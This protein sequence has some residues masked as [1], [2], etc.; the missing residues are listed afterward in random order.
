M[1]AG[2]VREGDERQ[3]KRTGMR[4]RVFLEEEK[5]KGK[6]ATRL[7]E[8]MAKPVTRHA[9]VKCHS[10]FKV[11]LSQRYPRCIRDTMYQIYEKSQPLNSS[12]ISTVQIY[13][14]QCLIQVPVP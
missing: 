7:N 12:N 8:S 3:L 14:L 13:L 9:S 4:K 5:K 11:G 10:G 6:V 2:R 1:G